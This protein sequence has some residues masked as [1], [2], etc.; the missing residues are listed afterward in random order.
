MLVH[1]QSLK[2]VS[3]KSAMTWAI[4]V[5]MMDPAG[6][7]SVCILYGTSLADIMEG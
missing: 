4:S 5:L 3:S 2:T 1:V 7:V 6:D